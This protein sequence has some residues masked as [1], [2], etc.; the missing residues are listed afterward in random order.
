LEAS[1]RCHLEPAAERPSVS[2]FSR[3]GTTRGLLLRGALPLSGFVLPRWPPRRGSARS[4]A[5]RLVYFQAVLN[6]LPLQV[7]GGGQI[8]LRQLG[9][10]CECGRISAC[11]P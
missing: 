7:L 3:Q 8:L 5:R 1:R 10:D 11:Q 2:P 6:L 9:A 4:A